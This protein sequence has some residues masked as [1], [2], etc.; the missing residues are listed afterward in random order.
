MINLFS[1][2]ASMSGIKLSLEEKTRKKTVK[3]SNEAK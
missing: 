3:A 2:K 1:Q